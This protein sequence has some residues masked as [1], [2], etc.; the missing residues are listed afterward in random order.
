V[1]RAG[2][3]RPPWGGDMVGDH[4]HAN[5]L[6]TLCLAQGACYNRMRGSKGNELLVS[7][8]TLW[9]EAGALVGL[10]EGFDPF[11]TEVLAGGEVTSSERGRS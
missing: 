7:L 9:A 2:G 6:I 1:R 4:K 8:V 10:R 3:E 11:C 5:S